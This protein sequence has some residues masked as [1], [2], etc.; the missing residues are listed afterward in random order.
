VAT[1]LNK[2]V[3]RESYA[4]IYEAGKTRPIIITLEPPSVLGF[5]AKGTRRIFRLTAERCYMLAVKRLVD[6]EREEKRKAKIA[7]RKANK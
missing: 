1:M 6:L 7:K 2:T 3:K 5:R 4:S